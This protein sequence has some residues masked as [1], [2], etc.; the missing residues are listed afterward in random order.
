MKRRRR[1]PEV[2]EVPL[3]D[4]TRHVARLGFV[5]GRI[6]SVPVHEHRVRE[7]VV[8]LVNPIPESL[9]ALV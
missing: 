1:V 7:A 4:P 6:T 9:K 8:S 3:R 2:A 5:G